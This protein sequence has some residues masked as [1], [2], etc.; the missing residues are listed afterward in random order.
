MADF[1]QFILDVKENPGKRVYKN[2]LDYT[3][4]PEAGIA[5]G[6][7]II[8][9][10]RQAHCVQD[11]IDYLYE[12]YDHFAEKIKEDR[13]E[14]CKNKNLEELFLE[15]A[16]PRWYSH[17]IYDLG[18]VQTFAT[19]DF[20]EL[21][22]A[23]DLYVRYYYAS[24]IYLELT[25][26]EGFASG[27]GTDHGTYQNVVT[28]CFALMRPDYARRF[29][30]EK[31]GLIR[32]SHIFVNR[33]GSLTMALLYDN[34]EWKEKALKDAHKYLQAKRSTSER[35]VVSYMINLYEENADGMSENLQELMDNYRKAG[36]LMIGE[37]CRLALY[38]YYLMAKFYLPE[39]VFMRVKR[40]QGPGW[41]DEYI[42][43]CLH[44]A[45]PDMLDKPFIKFPGRLG[46]INEALRAIDKEP[47][48]GSVI[49][50][51]DIKKH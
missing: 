32:R 25:R 19:G 46:F 6:G 12:K 3:A 37:G 44:G 34:D 9:E 33:L 22:K 4:V 5:R 10:K 30:P 24:E 11:F 14:Y 13:L 50:A 38:G 45:L 21:Y 29:Y 1:P 7:E 17:V 31:L 15:R 23:L 26:G 8:H 28:A 47:P 2:F 48:E 20:R 49:V 40:P 27:C 36:W 43:M 39:N 51:V 18:M 35:A 16:L 42:D 41:W